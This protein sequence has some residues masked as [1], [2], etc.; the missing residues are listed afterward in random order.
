MVMKAKAAEELHAA[1]A[2]LVDDLTASVEYFRSI[3]RLG[4]AVGIAASP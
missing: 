1:I 3:E 2:S 4:G